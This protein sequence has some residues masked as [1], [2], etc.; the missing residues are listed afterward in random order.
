MQPTTTLHALLRRLF[1]LS[2]ALMLLV[3]GTALPIVQAAGATIRDDVGLFTQAGRNKINSTASDANLNILVITNKQSFPTRADW[4]SWLRS[5]ATDP[6]AI[7]IGLHVLP[8]EPPGPRRQQIISAVPGA[9]THLS[10]PQADQAVANTKITFNQVGVTAGVVALINEFKAMGATSPGSGGSSGSVLDWLIPVIVVLV[11]AYLL[12]RLF[13]S[14]R[15]AMSGG[16]GQSGA[17]Y[18]G[19]N[20]GYGGP[21]FGGGGGFGRGLLGGLLGGLGGAWLGNQLFGNRGGDGNVNAGGYDPNSGNYD[22]NSGPTDT[23]EAQ[24]LQGGWGDNGV[25]ADSGSGWDSGSGD[26]GGGWDAGSGDSG[27]GWDSGGGG[28]SGGWN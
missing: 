1:P 3:A 22:P 9:N 5:Q 7:T 23:P 26:S 18:Q 4:Q 17:P 2:L 14:R 6:N 15:R 10:Q 16:Y 21:G 27:G 13:N 20:Q 19:Y 8:N 12:I 28:D 25:G 11:I 24:S